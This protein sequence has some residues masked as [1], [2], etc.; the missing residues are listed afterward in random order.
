MQISSP[1]FKKVSVCWS[2]FILPGHIFGFQILIEEDQKLTKVCELNQG[3]Q[4]QGGGW[5]AEA[6]HLTFCYFVLV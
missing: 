5:E 4:C 1:S 2:A 3:W 6:P